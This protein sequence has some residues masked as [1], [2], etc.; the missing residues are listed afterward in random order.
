MGMCAYFS[1]SLIDDAYIFFRYADH[2]VEGEGPVFNP[3]E[4][5]EGFTSPS[6]LALLAAARA[7]GMEYEPTVAVM[8]TLFALTAVMAS[9][10]LARR[11]AGPVAAL[12]AP[13]LMAFHPALAMWS[14]HG[15]ETALFVTLCAV[16][17]WAWH[18]DRKG[19]EAE[20]GLLAGL[21]FWTRPEAALVA[22]VL[23][24]AA[25]AE[26][27][28]RRTLRFAAWF[29]LAVVPLEIAR[30]AYYGSP[31]PNTWFAKT[32]GG[33]GRILFG[34]AYGKQ[35]ALTHAP[36]LICCAA[37]LW[38]FMRR[39]GH[40]P[41]VAG[42]VALCAV[43]A[44]YVVW[45]GGDA[46]PGYRFWLPVLPFTGALVACG[47]ERAGIRTTAPALAAGLALAVV[48]GLAALPDVRLEHETGREFTKKMTTAGRWLAEHAPG[49]LTI[50]VNYVG[51]LPYHSGLATI[52][53]LGLTDRTI[54][55]TPIEGRFRFPGHARGN[56]AA[57][58][59]GKPDLIL[60]NGVYLE[61]EPMRTLA[62]QLETEEQ[63]AAD[64]RF[65][66]DY[67]RVD[68]RLEPGEDALWFVFFKRK[69]LE[70]NPDR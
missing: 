14:V 61:P 53:M 57:V 20:T 5:V 6:W 49:D 9:W 34:L 45:V 10:A 52:D 16:S 55:R 68:V 54:A 18:G 7:L 63:I 27:R 8:G 30:L 15:L 21:A 17:V 29:A 47:M 60:M 51:A 38:F 11:F 23:A 19:S 25:V 37:A 69:D 43:W 12:A 48:T 62:P 44:G 31:V 13:V 33:A 22:M 3:G 65:A 39:R 67:R 70:W 24:A 42:I 41:S 46:F 36:L 4:R 40:G 56:G 1:G 35:F 66:A 50:A 28:F 26:G 59:D 2:L 32:G 58:L 64:P